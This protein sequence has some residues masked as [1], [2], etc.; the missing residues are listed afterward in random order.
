[1]LRPWWWNFVR[2]E[3]NFPKNLVA[4]YHLGQERLSESKKASQTVCL[5]RASTASINVAL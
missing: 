3:I 2:P 1:M 5:K 4:R